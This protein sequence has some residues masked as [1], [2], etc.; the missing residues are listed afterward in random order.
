MNILRRAAIVAV[1]SELLSS[2]KL[3]TNSL[4]ITEQLN[5]IGVEVVAK[6]VVGDSRDEL[7]FV[8]R[9]LLDRADLVILCG[10]L[11]LT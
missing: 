11:G 7:A 6:A 9:T 1:G 4:Y 2:A 10:G 3:D 8:V 5:R